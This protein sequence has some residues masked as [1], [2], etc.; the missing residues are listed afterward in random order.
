MADDELAEFNGDDKREDFMKAGYLK[1]T[2]AI[3]MSLVLGVGAN[4]SAFAAEAVTE[5]LVAAE[6]EETAAEAVEEESDAEEVIEEAVA[7][8]AV[9]EEAEVIVEEN[10]VIGDSQVNDTIG[11]GVS[12][13]TAGLAETLPGAELGAA[14]TIAEL[15]LAGL[16]G[17]SLS[18]E[19]VADKAEI[20]AVVDTFK[21]ED[22][23]TK[24]M[25][26]RVVFE[27]ATEEEAEKIAACYNGELVNYQYEIATVMLPENID[28]Y[29]AVNIASGENNSMPAVYLNVIYHA[30]DIEEQSF[31]EAAEGNAEEITAEFIEDE[32]SDNNQLEADLTEGKMSEEISVSVAEDVESEAAVGK[33]YND[34]YQSYQ[35]QNDW[36]N[37]GLAWNTSTG[38]GVTVAVLDTG[39]DLD[40]E[41]LQANLVPGYNAISAYTSADDDQGHGTHVAGIIAGVA[42]NGKGIAGIAPDAKIMPVKVLNSAGSGSSD[43]IVAGMRYVA[44]QK[45]VQVANMSLGAYMYDILEVKAVKE[46]NNAGI[47]LCAAAGNE[48]ESGYSYPACVPEALSVAALTSVSTAQN[49]SKARLATYSNYGDSVDIA[50]PGTKVYAT[51]FDGSYGYKSGT[52]MACPVV[53]GVAAVTLSA[54]SSLMKK[55]GSERANGLRNILLGSVKR[56]TYVL[57]GTGNDDACENVPSIYGGADALNGVE[58]AETY[59]EE[60]GAPE[61]TCTYLDEKESMVKSGPGSVFKLSTTTKNARIYYN[62]DEKNITVDNAIPYSGPTMLD[63]SGKHSIKAVAVIGNKYSKVTSLNKMFVA[64][65]ISITANNGNVLTIVPGGSADITLAPSPSYATIPV[66]NWTSSSDSFTVKKNVVVCSKEATPGSTATIKGTAADGSGVSVTLSVKCIA[67]ST[68][69]PELTENQITLTTIETTKTNAQG[70]LSERNIV[71]DILLNGGYTGSYAFVSSKPS[72]VKVNSKGKLTAVGKGKA[73]ITI[74][75]NDGS[76]KALKLNV[77]VITPMYAINRITTDTGFSDADDIPLAQGGKIKLK[78]FYNDDLSY[79]ANGSKLTEVASNKKIMWTS[80]YDDV[81]VKNNVIVSSK[82]ALPGVHVTL[83]GMPADGFGKPIV[84]HVTT[85]DAMS[86]LYF[87]KGISKNATKLVVGSGYTMSTIFNNIFYRGQKGS[88][89]MYYTDTYSLT[90]SNQAVFGNGGTLNKTSPGFWGLKP[91]SAKLVFKLRDG[92]GKKCALSVSI[93]NSKY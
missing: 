42:G 65:P 69:E 13:D 12:D 81:Q 43:W 88:S 27:A 53:A 72:V 45:N 7:A 38:K 29:T 25:A 87:G 26:D 3:M 63:I 82:N 40:H 66:F 31:G 75:K 76:K 44:K 74:K 30:Y 28:A 79:K 51:T 85:F 8:E 1:K 77:T 24:Y 64:T 18:E 56:E 83:T 23:G 10:A 41:D 55:T 59:G 91:G 58:L 71:N 22:E 5:D 4:C 90:S 17:M 32:Q 78:V 20:A 68:G 50:A 61:I 14:S 93:K 89:G 34:P 39:V 2:L 92:S 15:S 73:V 52:S 49:C 19:M 54:S 37:A 60:I 9:S 48:S 47:L 35:W 57:D 21:K 62:I 86:V 11:E 33:S 36:V 46:L 6:S 70:V 80:S 84:L 67:E 16:H